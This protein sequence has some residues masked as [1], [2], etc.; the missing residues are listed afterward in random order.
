MVTFDGFGA[1]FHLET[2]GAIFSS[3]SKVVLSCKLSILLVV[4][5]RDG[6]ALS[7]AA[8]V[9]A[10]RFER[11]RRRLQSPG[12]TVREVEIHLAAIGGAGRDV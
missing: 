11:Y 4:C 9:G 1:V 6:S 3:H 8:V 5:G 2:V 10:R 12:E 7:G